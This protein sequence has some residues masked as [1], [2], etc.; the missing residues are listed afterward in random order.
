MAVVSHH[1]Q[2]YH[3]S[4]EQKGAFVDCIRMLQNDFAANISIFSRS[5][6]MEM[7][8]ELYDI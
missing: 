3:I 2:I 8:K 7:L 1:V 6:R 5:V 4:L